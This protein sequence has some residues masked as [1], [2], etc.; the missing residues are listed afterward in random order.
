MI[1]RLAT[2]ASTIARRPLS[3]RA[4][5]ADSLQP[6]YVNSTNTIAAPSLPTFG[7]VENGGGSA[8]AVA[9]ATSPATTTTTRP[10]TSTMVSVFC[11]RTDTRSPARLI[12]V[13][14]PTMSA[15]HH[16][17]EYDPSETIVDT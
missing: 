12:A 16:A 1:A 9:G 2:S 14:A 13:N 11:V 10:S 4:M 17:D 15:A 8:C 6:P 3:S 7:V 5:Y